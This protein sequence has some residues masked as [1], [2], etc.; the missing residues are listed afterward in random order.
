MTGRGRVLG[1]H[2]PQVEP[3]V[4]IEARR[5]LDLRLPG[6]V[7][8]QAR[9][10]AARVVR[11]QPEVEDALAVRSTLVAP[12]PT[13]VATNSSLASVKVAWP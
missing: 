1:R 11:V 13:P 4:E 9:V 6:G 10:E 5:Q 2:Q 12:T 8:E 3:E 7:H